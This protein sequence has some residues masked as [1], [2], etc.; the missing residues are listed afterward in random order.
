MP[1]SEPIAE[2]YKKIKE[3]P[4]SD[5]MAKAHCFPGLSDQQIK[6]RQLDGYKFY[7]GKVRDLLIKGDTIQMIHSDR[8]TAFD[9]Y[10]SVVPFK[11][12]L[13]AA[14]SE[15]WLNKAKEIV[16]THFIDRPSEKVLKVE[17]LEPIKV[18]VIVRGYLAGSMERA[19][20]KGERTFCGQELPEGL[21]NFCQLPD[22][23]ITPTTK[24]EVFEHDE[25]T[26]PEK[27]I[28]AG[29]CTQK[30]WTQIHEMALA[31]FKQGTKINQSLGWILVDTK[32]E[33]GRA[34]NGTIKLIDE[35][36]TP[37]SSRFWVA[38]S[39]DERISLGKA[40]E[41]LDKEIVRRWLMDEG[42]QG[43]GEVPKVPAKVLINLGEVYLKVAES[44]T[45]E[46]ILSHKS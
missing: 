4:D 18:E 40:P 28:A 14:I 13:L 5:E 2:I 16:P 36:H 35:I 10:I 8:L 19:Y 44:L 30:E 3:S 38:S 24:A 6:S 15:F 26:T 20:E 32:Y 23:I 25:D 45:G 7:R 46:P 39:Y 27:L 31:L 29:V 41:M 21:I 12:T 42:F 1:M 11:G 43:E 17:A 22:V 34:R 37:D 9:K 33:F